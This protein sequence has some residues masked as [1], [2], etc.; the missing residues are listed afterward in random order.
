MMSS[1]LETAHAAN[2]SL[3]C[4]HLACLIRSY[5][6]YNQ[7]RNVKEFYVTTM[8]LLGICY[9]V[10]RKV[11]VAVAMSVKSILKGSLYVH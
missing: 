8:S 5:W 7:F 2:S 10:R 9:S 4:F 6:D 11:C 1:T 3:N